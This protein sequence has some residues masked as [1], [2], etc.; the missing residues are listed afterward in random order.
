LSANP[1]TSTPSA[2][3]SDISEKEKS[4]LKLDMFQHILPIKHK[5]RLRKK[6]KDCFHMRII[7]PH[8][9]LFDL[10]TRF[11]VMDS[12]EEIRQVLTLAHPALEDVLGP[13]DAV[14]MAR[15]ANDE[16]AEQIGRAHV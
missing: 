8:P 10:E 6:V 15:F 9:A 12:H 16:M 4:V 2:D 3:T 5:E 13:E 7:E 14:A 1:E 11:R